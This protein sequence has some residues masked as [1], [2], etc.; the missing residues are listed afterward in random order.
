MHIYLYVFHVNM[1]TQGGVG[2]GVWIHELDAILDSPVT[3][4]NSGQ[5]SSFSAMNTRGSKTLCY[6]EMIAKPTTT[7]SDSIY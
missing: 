5:S 2:S 4:E 1:R 7:G 6:K 3:V